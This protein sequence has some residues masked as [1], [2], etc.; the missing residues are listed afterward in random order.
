MTTATGKS[1]PVLAADRIT[2]IDT[3]RG[4]AVLGILVMNI[5][6]FAMPFV[7]Y[8]NPLAMGGTEWYNL[9]TWF[10]THILF[11]QKFLTIFA[12]LFGA[13]LVMTMTRA[14][15]RE[16]RYAGNWYR[17]NFWLL[18]IGAAHG[19]LLWFGDILFH[20]ALM[21]M[22][23]FPFRH[24]SPR[25]L[26]I[27][28]S[29]LLAFGVLMQ[30]GGGMQMA[31][32]SVKGPAVL[33]LDEAGETL[34]EEQSAILR[35]WESM[36]A[37]VKP[38]EQQVAEDVAA[39]TGDYAGILE[40]RAPMVAMMQTQATI[41]FVIWRVGGLML[42]G[43][44]LM[45][46]GILS[47]DRSDAFYRKMMMVG[48]GVGLPIMLFSSWLMLT[49]R[50]EML[51]MFRVGVLPNYVGSIFVAFGHI[52]LLMTIVRGGLMQSLMDR[53]TAVGRMAFTNYLM[54]SVILTTV[55][56]GYGLGL[57]GQIPR[58]WQ[59]LFVAGVLGFQL[60]FSPWWLARFRFGPA[61]WLWRSLSYWK[62]QPMPKAR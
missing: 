55:F 56:Y 47:G 11:D 54:H 61:E 32:M 33:A 36:S 17:R 10:L 18:L 58:I 39:Y 19:Y 50:W 53:F 8:Q 13:G 23:I 41:G 2:S 4:V 51:W 14:E 35:Q 28:A 49:N 7:A 27:I 60:W 38:P 24:R 9:G 43:M 6:A 42:L 31:E 20:Y 26:I 25:T 48:Y 16:A 5:Y 30:V 52:A 57:Y 34:T 37:F 46:L 59:M 15:A 45:K 1:Q 62:L 22:L 3:L 21:G 40:H 12:V 29:I 44:A